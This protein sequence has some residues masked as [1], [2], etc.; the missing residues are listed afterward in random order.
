MSGS[1]E[2]E[3]SHDDSITLV[4]QALKPK[5]DYV[6]CPVLCYLQ[7]MFGKRANKLVEQI[8]FA[9]Y[10]EKELESAKCQL[11]S[12]SGDWVQDLST[13]IRAKHRGGRPGKKIADASDIMSIW[14][15][16]ENKGHVQSLPNYVTSTVMRIPGEDPLNTDPKI[17]QSEVKALRDELQQL[18]K[19][20]D[21]KFKELQKNISKPADAAS[22]T[23]HADLSLQQI[24][25]SSS[26]SKPAASMHWE[27]VSS[28]PPKLSGG[29]MAAGGTEPLCFFG[30]IFPLSNFYECTVKLHDQ[31][32]PTS[33]HAFQYYR[34]TLTGQM[35]IA[36][37]ILS[38]ETPREAKRLGDSTDVSSELQPVWED[39]IASVMESVC[40]HK[41]SQNTEAKNFLLG[42][43]E[44]ELVE[45]SVDKFWGC[46]VS[47]QDPA[48][49][50]KSTWTGRN[51]LGRILV[52]VRSRLRDE[53]S[54]P[55]A[56]PQVVT[57]PKQQYPF[58]AGVSFAEVLKGHNGWNLVQNLKKHKVKK[59]QGT[60]ADIEAIKGVER[61]SSMDFYVGQL[62][63]DT[64]KE[65]LEKFLKE[66][67]IK[68]ELGIKLN[69][70]IQN[71][72]AFR[73]RCLAEHRNTILS[74]SF[75]PT[76][77]SVRQ[78]IRRPRMQ[79]QVGAFG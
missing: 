32:F 46:G 9:F 6:D 42:T 75:W 12:D 63:E 51:T 39:T 77:V 25:I 35:G 55:L 45:A 67:E 29:S 71:T 1:E 78:W 44:R 37:E 58:Q 5:V 15:H 40:Q 2:E 57:L 34:A 64:S 33:E 74:D 27:G 23:S 41:F 16:V 20:M 19:S 69:T 43:G 61:K 24:P 53:S 28:E 17:F 70:K 66:N 38:A 7:D 14:V 50:N 56:V 36:E 52:K 59:T 21:I 10:S 54:L 68:M 72:A 47:L 65:D 8:L 73:F 79:T 60:N 30:K 49:R 11:L 18:T 13:N 4:K 22:V 3:E 26:G 76:H 62:N 31:E 48:L